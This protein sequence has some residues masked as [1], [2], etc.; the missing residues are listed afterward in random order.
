MPVCKTELEQRLYDALKRITRYEN[1]DRLR[2]YGEK[3]YGLSGDECIEMAYENVL[4][5]AANGI[6]GVRARKVAPAMPSSE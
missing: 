6:R 5:E 4:Q 3:N 1:P 2:K